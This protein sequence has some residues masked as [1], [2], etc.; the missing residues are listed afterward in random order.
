MEVEWNIIYRVSRVWLILNWNTS[1][2]WHNITHKIIFILVQ[3]C[4]SCSHGNQRFDVC[5]RM[6]GCLPG[7][8]AWW[9]MRVICEELGAN[10]IDNDPAFY[11]QDGSINDGYLL[12]DGVHLTRAATNKIVSNLQLHLRQGETNAHRDHRKR[13]DTPGTAPTQNPAQVATQSDTQ[14]TGSGAAREDYS[15]P[16]WDKARHKA[17]KR[18]GQPAPNPSTPSISRPKM[19]RQQRQVNNSPRFPAGKPARNAQNPNPLSF[20]NH[21]HPY[22]PRPQPVQPIPLMD[23]DTYPPRPNSSSGTQ[24]QLCLGWAH[25]AVTCRSKDAT[26][27]KCHSIG[28]FSRA[29]PNNY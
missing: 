10:F 29:C 23:I 12:P 21:P 25:T 2:A 26:C 16:F 9:S 11:L 24:C 1:C 17:N 4:E 19:L 3:T 7:N 14:G 27:Y 22:A 20:P 18:F 5:H 28:H 13:G 8:T 6:I 15:N